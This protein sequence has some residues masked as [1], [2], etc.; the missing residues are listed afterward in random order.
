MNLRPAGAEASFDLADL[1]D[2]AFDRPW[3]ALEFE[4]LL[5]S[6]GV[7]AVLGEAGDPAEAKGFI[8]CRS[9]AGEA[10]ILT[11]AVDPA[12]RRR[13]W[14]AA[15]VE[16]AAGIAAETGAEA[17]FLEV[18]VD[19]VAAVALYQASRFA[20]VGVRKGYYPHPDGAKD[21]VVMRRAL[22]T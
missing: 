15:L 5:K 14:G 4:E 20:K 22:N 7:F 10:E 2:K 1:H 11:I 9:I 12:A 19:N 13:G 6:P 17:L 16:V 3:T 8:L 21:A 18:A